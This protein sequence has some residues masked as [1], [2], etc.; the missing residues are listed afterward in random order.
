MHSNII[1]IA[2]RTSGLMFTRQY[3]CIYITFSALW[4]RPPSLPQSFRKISWE[5][6][7]QQRNDHSIS[8]IDYTQ[9]SYSKIRDDIS[10]GNSWK[11][12]WVLRVET[13][14]ET[15]PYIIY[16]ISTNLK[17]ALF[18]VTVLDMWLAALRYLLGGV[19]TMLRS[20]VSSYF[21]HCM[22]QRVPCD[23][24]TWGLHKRCND[25]QWLK[26]SVMQHARFIFDCG[27]LGM[28][29]HLA[30]TNCRKTEIWL[31]TFMVATTTPGPDLIATICHVGYLED[32][33]VNFRMSPEWSW[34]ASRSFCL[35]W[36]FRF[37]RASPFFVSNPCRT[38]AL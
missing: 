27:W 7:R 17:Y 26:C 25:M 16:R 14:T 12:L 19:P 2:L 10:G 37:W 1:S 20:A 3:L 22:S 30:W 6:V 33:Q 18:T 15:N 13:N 34:M 23:D 11:K 38:T 5:I 4:P 36:L 29:T 35:A 8:L 9:I 28:K 21:S 32:L 24:V 31:D